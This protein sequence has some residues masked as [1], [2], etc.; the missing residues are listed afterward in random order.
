MVGLDK[1]ACIIEKMPSPILSE[2]DTQMNIS[3]RNE[4]QI[5]PELI[6]EAHKFLMEL[7][8]HNKARFQDIISLLEKTE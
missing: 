2:Q 5:T 8:A 7:N 6:L 1:L 3:D 4:A